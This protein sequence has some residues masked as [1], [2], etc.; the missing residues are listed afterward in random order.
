MFPLSDPPAK[1]VPGLTVPLYGPGVQTGELVT[2]T[3]PPPPTRDFT[4]VRNSWSR[5]ATLTWAEKGMLAYI[6]GHTAEHPLTM[7]QTIAEGAE[8]ADAVRSILRS[9]EAKGWLTRTPVRGYRGRVVRY[10]Y[11]VREPEPVVDLAGLGPTASGPTASGEA[12][13]SHDLGKVG[14]SAG[15]TACRPTAS[16]QPGTKKTTPPSEKKTKKTKSADDTSP[17]A[18]NAGTILAGF[19]D[20]LRLEPQGAIELPGRIRGQYARNLKDLLDEGHPADRIKHALALMHERGRTSSPSL[21]A[22]FVVEVQNTPRRAEPA[23]RLSF[24]EQDRRRRE[25]GD[26]RAMAIDALM[27][28]QPGLGVREAA[29]MVDEEIR[30]R[31]D[32]RTGGAY[33]DGVPT[34]GT[35]APEVTA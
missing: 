20:W 34:S 4:Q 10:D 32:A 29:R 15:A 27:E 12:A 5:D 7:E 25:E 30:K 26:R 35:A 1:E 14:V 6:V 19:I 9:L 22:S 33:I 2:V 8:G 24:A 3:A 17:A 28:A 11:A 23:E 16:S 13:T 21:L 18:V 31:V